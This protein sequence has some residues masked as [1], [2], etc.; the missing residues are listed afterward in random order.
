[1]HPD[2]ADLDDDIES[3]MDIIGKLTSSISLAMNIMHTTGNIMQDY[4][5]KFGLDDVD[6]DFL[7]DFNERNID[8]W[9]G[10]LKKIIRK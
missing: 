5:Y 8:D 6:A 9:T 7:A 3:L 4:G 10:E 2:D 1:M